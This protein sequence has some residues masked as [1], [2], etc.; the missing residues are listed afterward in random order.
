MLERSASRA[1]ALALG[2]VLGLGCETNVDLN[3]NDGGWDWSDGRPY[4]S[5]ETAK[6]AVSDSG[7]VDV[8]TFVGA[9]AVRM[10]APDTVAVVATRRADR[11]TD[12]AMLEVAMG[13]DANVV[14]IAGTNPANARDV[15]VD[16]EISGPSDMKVD[17]R[18]GVGPVS[19]TGR[20]SELWNIDVGVGSVTLAIPADA[21]VTVYLTS[22]VGTIEVRL[23]VQGSV[24]S[25]DVV[26][27]IGTGADGVII[28]RC[29]V[30]SITLA[31]Q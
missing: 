27:T 2:A 19:C 18:T 23:P 11:E 1:A 29:G 30:G 25:S 10:G 3:A 28:A 4:S 14:T 13:V 15:S 7:S 9:I 17:A 5:Q 22:G 6:F 21:N 12:L 31:A 24:S 20:P 16:F 8:D 26:G